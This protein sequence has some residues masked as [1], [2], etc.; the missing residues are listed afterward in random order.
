MESPDPSGQSTPLLPEGTARNLTHYSIPGAAGNPQVLRSRLRSLESDPSSRGHRGMEGSA[1]QVLQTFFHALL[2][3][4]L[5]LF[6]IVNPLGMAPIFLS[7][8]AGVED[9]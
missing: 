5:A 4:A 3:V 2:F 8:T 6:P 7:F 1:L 9:R